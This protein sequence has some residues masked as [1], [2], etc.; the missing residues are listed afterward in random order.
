[1]NRK[2]FVKIAGGVVIKA[3]AAYYFQ[4]DIHFPEKYTHIF[5]A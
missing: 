1:M 2:K 5:N 3:G 4:S